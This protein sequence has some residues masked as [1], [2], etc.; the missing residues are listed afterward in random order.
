[1]YGRLV[2][3]LRSQLVSAPSADRLLA[4]GLAACGLAEIWLLGNGTAPRGLASAAVLAMTLPLAVRRSH[5][6]VVVGATVMALAVLFAASDFSSDDDAY[7]PWF[8]LL[9]V[10]YTAGA[11]TSGAGIA[12]GAAFTL[13]IPVVISATDRD[14][15]TLDGVIFFSTFALPPF[16]AGVAVARRRRREATLERH[17]ARLDA[18]RERA[19]AAAVTEERARIARELHDLVAHAVSTMVVQAQGG[20]RMVRVEP[21]EAEDAFVA[22]ERTGRRALT[23]MRR[24][25]GML[26][27]ADERAALAPQP[28][29]EQ[30]SALVDGVRSAGLRV[31]LRVEGLVTPLPPGVD[32]SA[33]RIVQEALTNTLKHAGPAHAE[34][35]LR[36]E[37]GAVELEVAD[38]GAGN[39]TSRESG[40]QGLV[41][42]RERVSIY[43]GRLEA[44]ARP[45]GGYVVRARLP[46][47]PAGR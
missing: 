35:C 10:A 29:V 5:P 36:Y 45:T 11:Y 26:R 32:V 28:G 33:Y 20:A 37:P 18:D 47:E 21:D 42:M 2:G 31:D 3:W 19:A 24:L 14:G 17:A 22:I 12:V 7:L 15:F 34:V 23:E 8:L 1:V 44:G 27:A 40:G 6:L 9:L 39:G 16:L 41:G 13:A 4:V 38:D 46:F 25:L 43:G 30:L